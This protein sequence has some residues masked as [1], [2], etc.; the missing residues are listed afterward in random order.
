MCALVPYPRDITQIADSNAILNAEGFNATKVYWREPAEDGS[1][2]Y[3]FCSSKP[4][5]CLQNTLFLRVVYFDTG[6]PAPQMSPSS[7]ERGG[8]NLKEKEVGE[9]RVINGPYSTQQVSGESGSDLSLG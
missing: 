8:G 3:V 1:A 2:N 7:W 5:E 6:E 9:V 4:T